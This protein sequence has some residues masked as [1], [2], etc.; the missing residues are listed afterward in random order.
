MDFDTYTSFFVLPPE[1]QAEV[2]CGLHGD[3]MRPAA[4]H[5][6]EDATPEAK[7]LE[8]QAKA[9]TTQELM[10][11]PAAQQREY[12]RPQKGERGEFQMLRVSHQTGQG[13]PTDK[14]LREILR[15]DKKPSGSV[16]TP[17]GYTFPLQGNDPYTSTL[18]GNWEAYCAS[19]ITTSEAVRLR[20]YS[21]SVCLLQT[22]GQC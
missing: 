17:L 9:M 11:A 15:A 12:R 1:R 13:W 20:Q 16:C 14:D 2:D 3:A 5:S 19:G 8:Q 6:H 18:S 22:P 7:E 4:R 10:A 21:A